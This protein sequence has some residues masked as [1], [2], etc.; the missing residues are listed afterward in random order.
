MTT[1]TTPQIPQNRS[2]NGINTTEKRFPRTLAEAFPKHHPE[3]FVPIVIH[4]PQRMNPDWVVI[5]TCLV[6]LGFLLGVL[7]S[8]V[9]R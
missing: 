1:Q 7:V 8:E 9:A 3:Y 5:G 6:A 2:S 4:R